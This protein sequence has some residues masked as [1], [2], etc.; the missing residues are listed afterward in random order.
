L[1][2]DSHH[3]YCHSPL[4]SLL[5][6]YATFIAR[7]SRLPHC[8]SSLHSHSLSL[9][10]ATYTT[11][12]AF[13]LCSDTFLNYSYYTSIPS[14]YT[15]L[16]RISTS[17]YLYYCYFHLFLLLILLLRYL[18]LSF[19]EHSC[20]DVVRY[21]HLLWYPYTIPPLPLL[22]IN[23]FP[24]SQYYLPLTLLSE[25]PHLNTTLP[26]ITLLALSSHLIITLLLHYH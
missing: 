26:L 5:T 2:N 3:Y 22:P 8:S 6:R 1:F 16:F 9:Y 19:M 17:S 18:R 13:P 14:S 24:S 10:S 4:T 25:L 7:H 20:R 15:S 12:S 23:L 11:T 21:L